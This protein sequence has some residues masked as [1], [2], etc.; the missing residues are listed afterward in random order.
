MAL[1]LSPPNSSSLLAMAFASRLPPLGVSDSGA[2]G[3]SDSG[4]EGVSEEGV[5]T[6]D[7]SDDEGV[8]EGVSDELVPLP[9][10]PA[11]SMA[12]T[13]SAESTRQSTACF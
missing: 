12:L 5:E 3:V 13:S 1:Q 8:E 6:S 2:D 11:K 4:V 7:L 9:P 10:Q